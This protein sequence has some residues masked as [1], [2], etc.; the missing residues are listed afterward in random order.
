MSLQYWRHILA[1]HKT[2]FWHSLAPL[3]SMLGLLVII[4]PITT[5]EMTI[6]AEKITKIG[7]LGP[8]IWHFSHTV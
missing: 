5:C 8:K 1:V 7:Q 2:S 6:F 4:K 3:M